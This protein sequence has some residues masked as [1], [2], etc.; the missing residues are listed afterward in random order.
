MNAW[1]WWYLAAFYAT[2][3]PSMADVK[4]FPR[5]GWGDRRAL[6]RLC[7]LRSRHVISIYL[8]MCD[9]LRYPL[10]TVKREHSHL[11]SSHA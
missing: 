7:G 2:K 4:T 8:D 5:I 10:I 11:D 3:N 6:K 9:D 1:W